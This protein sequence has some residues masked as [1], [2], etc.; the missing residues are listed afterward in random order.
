M[1]VDARVSLS[2]GAADITDV[3]LSRARRQ[4]VYATLAAVWLTGILWL[5]FHYYLMG[6]G[7][8]GVAPHPLEAWWLRLHGAAALM[9]LFLLGMLWVLHIR[10]GLKRPRRR[11]SGVVLIVIFGVLTVSGYLLYYVNSDELHDAVR[12]IHWVVGAALVLPLLLH[13]LRAQRA[14]LARDAAAVRV[15]D[16]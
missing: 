15:E 8:F 9:T 7:E 5:F 14:R 3:R 12:L 1:S 4:L 13:V 16:V 11:E 6:E 2:D 10:P